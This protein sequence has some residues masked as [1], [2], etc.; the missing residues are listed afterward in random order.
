MF[1]QAG[2]CRTELTGYCS[3]NSAFLKFEL[4]LI[5]YHQRVIQRLL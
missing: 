1:A 3:F 2:F 5:K 4:L